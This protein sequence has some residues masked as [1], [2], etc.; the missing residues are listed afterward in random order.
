MINPEYKKKLDI[1]KR[2]Q[3]EIDS[4]INGESLKNF[5]RIGK[6]LKGYSRYIDRK[7]ILA[8]LDF[9]KIAKLIANNENFTIVSGLNPSSPLHLG[10]KVVFDILLDFQDN[11]KK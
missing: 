1:L 9:E 10:H 6:Y 3:N 7:I 4:K 11:I 5:S 2:K 8:H